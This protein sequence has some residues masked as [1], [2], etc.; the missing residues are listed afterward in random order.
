M[1]IPPYSR[2]SFCQRA[3]SGHKIWLY[4]SLQVRG[5]RREIPLLMYPPPSWHHP[6]VFQIQFHAVVRGF[7]SHALGLPLLSGS[8]CMPHLPSECYLIWPSS[9]LCSH[10]CNALCFTVAS[11]PVIV[12]V[13]FVAR[14]FFISRAS[15]RLWGDQFSLS[16]SWPPGRWC[17]IPPSPVVASL[18]KL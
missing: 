13:W 10:W 5:L 15:L 2:R 6:T 17:I 9:W 4:L 3:S 16:L 12:I 18:S 7:S 1:D 14:I 8:H 11:L